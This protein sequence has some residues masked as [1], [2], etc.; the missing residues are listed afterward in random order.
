M[1]TF[2]SNVRIMKFEINT[3]SSTAHFEVVNLVKVIAYTFECN[4]LKNNLKT[5]KPT[6]RY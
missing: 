1:N 4:G 2:I 3:L 6:F 5:K